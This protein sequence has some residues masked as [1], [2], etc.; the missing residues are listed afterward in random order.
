[1]GSINTF[2]V[3]RE[4][5]KLDTLCDLYESLTISQAIIFCKTKRK[6][7]WLDE[8][9]SER[10]FTC[11]ALHGEMDQRDRDMVIQQF[12][13]GSSRVLLTTDCLA[14]GFDCQQ[15]NL[16]INYDLPVDR[17]DYIHRIGRSGRF[18]RKGVAINFVTAYDL[19]QMRDIETYYHSMWSELPGSLEI[20]K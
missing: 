20:T 5:Y 16:V 3:E 9:M 15:V 18:G 12:L 11:S 1:M 10:D 6:V 19:R 4:E 2:D 14:R 8:K 17:A 7:D 13:S